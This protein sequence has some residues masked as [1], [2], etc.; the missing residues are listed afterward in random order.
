MDISTAGIDLNVGEGNMDFGKSIQT[1]MGKYA[2]F[3]GRASRSEF[4]WF[5]LFTIMLS[6]GASV[7]GALSFGEGGGAALSL[8]TNLAVMLPSFA[9]SSR[10]LHDTNRSGWWVLLALTI[11]GIIPLIIW[12]A[13]DSDKAANQYGAPYFE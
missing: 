11:I 7:V 12:W 2:T 4:W 13:Q 6:W 5:Y 10:R 9:A 3:E 1:C 8:L